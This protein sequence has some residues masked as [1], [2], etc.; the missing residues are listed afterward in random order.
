M[1]KYFDILQKN[2]YRGKWQLLMWSLLPLLLICYLLAFKKHFEL[3]VI[4]VPT[5]KRHN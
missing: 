1:L 2:D 4:L 5:S 3:S